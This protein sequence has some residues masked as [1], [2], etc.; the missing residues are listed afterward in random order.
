ML[1]LPPPRGKALG[2]A[3]ERAA[4]RFLR[5]AGYRLVM[6]NVL[7]G[8]GEIDLIMVA[9]DRHTIVLVEVK[10]R[11]AHEAT[12]RPLYNP[13]VN[14]DARKRAA[15]LRAARAIARRKGWENRPL[16]VDVVAVEWS[17]TGRHVIRHHPGAM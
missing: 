15:M 4:A 2:A 1:R 8:G 3:G 14:I 6:R 11:R 12:G 9:P 10:T 7:A 13:E 17:S 5:R 16:R